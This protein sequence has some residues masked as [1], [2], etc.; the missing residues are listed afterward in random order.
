MQYDFHKNREWS[1]IWGQKT[2]MCKNF[3]NITILLKAFIYLSVD[4][5]NNNF[6]CLYLCATACVF[7]TLKLYLVLKII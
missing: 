4:F 6:H 3:F 5:V 1:I 7:L 2:F